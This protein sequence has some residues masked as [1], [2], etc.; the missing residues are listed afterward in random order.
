MPSSRPCNERDGGPAVTASGQVAVVFG[1]RPEIIKL[2]PVVHEL[3]DRATTIHTGQHFDDQMS[4]TF[5]EQL[6]IGE[7]DHHLDVG[8]LTRGAQIGRATIAIEELLL[9]LRPACVVVQ[10]D[11]NSGLAGALAANAA[12][13]PI[14]HLEAGLRSF[15]RTMPEEHNRVLID[16]LSERCLAPHPSNA[17]L[18]RREGVSPERIRVTG[19][20]L[21]EALDRILPSAGERA[22]LLAELGLQPSRFVLATVH[23]VENADDP[24]KLKAILEQLAALPLPVVLPL[25]PR[26]MARAREFGMLQLLEGV[27]LVEPLGYRE[28]IA[29]AAECAL[30]ISDSGGVQEEATIVK[31]PVVVI[32]S[33]T[34]RPELLG[35]FAHLVSAGPEIST[36]ACRLLE[37]IAQTHAQLREL[38]Y[39]YGVHASARCV[40]AI[41]ELAGS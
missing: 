40:E 26:A 14:V 9:R 19:S 37:T 25:H 28:F 6:D 31:R 27:Q 35:T 10:G 41:D 5:L 21:K 2:A 32:R 11:T 23:R 18:L 3:G 20:T 34:E 4:R 12:L 38:P 33:S 1:T 39:P 8:G 24:V 30:L 16:A 7:P 36:V 22:S 13:I 15:D 29:L 17:E